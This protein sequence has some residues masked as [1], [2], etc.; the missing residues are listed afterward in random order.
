MEKENQYSRNVS[1]YEEID[2]RDVFNVLIRKKK[3]L[4]FARRRIGGGAGCQRRFAAAYRAQ[5]KIEVGSFE[6][7]AGRRCCWLMS[8]S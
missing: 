8:L 6:M 7:F 4:F 2:L 1:E 5:T 3:L